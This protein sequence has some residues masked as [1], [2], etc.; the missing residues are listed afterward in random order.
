LEE[1]NALTARHGTPEQEKDLQSLWSQ[2]PTCK[3]NPFP[4]C[5]INTRYKKG[6]NNI[7]DIIHL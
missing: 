6:N 4:R 7:E 1:R 3:R 2:H 5:Y